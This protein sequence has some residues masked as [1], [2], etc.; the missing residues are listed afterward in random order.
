L[1]SRLRSRVFRWR[2]RAVHVVIEAVRRLC[3]RL[4]DTMGASGRKVNDNGKRT[5][6]RAGTGVARE[7]QTTG[8]WLA[9]REANWSGKGSQASNEVNDV[10]DVS[11]AGRSVR[12]D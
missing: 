6:L 7:I 2:L 10:A 5:R 12:I 3:R 1:G 4:T 8:S 11:R 9:A